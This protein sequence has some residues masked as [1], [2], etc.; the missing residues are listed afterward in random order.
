MKN[1]MLIALLLCGFVSLSQNENDDKIL[2]EKASVLVDTYADIYNQYYDELDKETSKKFEKSFSKRAIEL[3]NEILEKPNSKFY[4]DAL[5]LKA[6][7]QY[8]LEDNIAAKQNLENLIK[9]D[10]V[11]PRHLCYSYLYL[12]Q[13]LIQEKDFKAASNY[14]EMHAKYPGPFGCG[15]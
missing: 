1:L 13:I 5:F 8:S 15:N 12:T 2:F 4:T 14:L 3:L 6:E 7:I 10:D 9:R 11:T